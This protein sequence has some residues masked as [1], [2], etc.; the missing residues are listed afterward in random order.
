MKNYKYFVILPDDPMKIIWDFISILILI[1]VFG[2][3][4]YR[5]GFTDNWR[6]EL[7][8]IDELIDAYYLLDIIIHI[9]SAYYN[10][11]FILIDH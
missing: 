1:F 10:S 3:T 9:F 6:V 4:P 7:I 11:G 5:V 2:Y 8:V